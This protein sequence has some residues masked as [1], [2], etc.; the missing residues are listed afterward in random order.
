MKTIACFITTRCR[1][2]HNGIDQRMNLIVRVIGGPQNWTI[3][4]SPKA[5]ASSVVLI[6]QCVS[7]W[8]AMCCRHLGNI[9]ATASH[10]LHVF[11]G[12][13]VTWPFIASRRS[14]HPSLPQWHV[15]NVSTLRAA[16]VYLVRTTIAWRV[17]VARMQKV[18][19]GSTIGMLSSSER[20]HVESAN[21]GWP[22]AD[23]ASAK[24]CFATRAIL[25]SIAT[26][27]R[28]GIRMRRL[29]RS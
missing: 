27:K 12:A 7:V 10:A 3:C 21:I 13:D 29:R 9:G 25:R 2:K 23:V 18:Y 5:Y 1:T 6:L 22:H 11:T 28:R 16:L 19:E 15:R 14:E 24:T 20:W 8:S 26:E 4:L 17:T